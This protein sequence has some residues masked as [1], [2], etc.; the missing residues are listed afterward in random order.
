MLYDV[1]LDGSFNPA[2]RN[3]F[4]DNL[5]DDIKIC[6]LFEESYD[7]LDAVGKA[8]LIAKEL[9]FIEQS[10]VVVFYL[11]PEWKSHFTM[12]KLGDAVGR[13]KQVIVCIEGA[14]ESEEKIRR[15]C[16]YRGVVI[17][18][19]L[20]DLITVTEEYIGQIELCQ[21]NPDAAEKKNP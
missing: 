6:D 2:W 21:Y 1:Y 7:Q 12:L 9:Q 11:H 16:E 13:G 20:D 3:Q 19:T 4:C 10:Q 8:N 14:I 5:S 17:V 18:E 15:Y